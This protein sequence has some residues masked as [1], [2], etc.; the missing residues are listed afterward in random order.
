MSLHSF[1]SQAKCINHERVF[2]NLAEALKLQEFGDILAK[3][4]AADA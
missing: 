4:Q 2:F 1:L 3:L